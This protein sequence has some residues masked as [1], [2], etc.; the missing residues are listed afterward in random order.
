MEYKT[1]IGVLTELLKKQ[2]L[3]IEEKEAVTTAIGVLDCAAL[4]QS[5]LKSY[6]KS[7]KDKKDKSREW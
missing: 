5:Q 2:V 7:K 3:N 1:A 6:I 4:G